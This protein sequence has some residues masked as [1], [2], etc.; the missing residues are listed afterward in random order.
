MTSHSAALRTK[1]EIA[2][3]AFHQVTRKLWSSTDL[4][5]RYPDYL[6]LMHTV[7]RATVPLMRTA[8][9]QA[10]AMAGEDAVAAGV[11][12]YLTKHIAEEQ[13][14]D[15]WLR[16]DLEA[17]GC[18]S[19]VRLQEMPRPSAASLVGCQYYWV[20]HY[21]P[22]CLLGHI[23]V[24]EGYPPV[25]DLVDL[26]VRRT[27][28][29]RT[30]MRTLIR[31][32]ALDLKHRDELMETIDKLPLS[33]AHTAAMGVSALYTVQG[34]TSMFDELLRLPVPQQPQDRQQHGGRIKGT[35]I[36]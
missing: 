1:I 16:Q 20:Q 13:G 4:S 32:A 3:P 21:H 8:L 29:P 14:H 9:E 17:I 12:A 33:T 35:T 36:Y 26:V 10:N 23:A 19:G 27:G 30:G 7:I 15:G 2:L 25:H 28:Y 22:V 6:V 18:D 31:H 34:V 5:A 24:L 11:A